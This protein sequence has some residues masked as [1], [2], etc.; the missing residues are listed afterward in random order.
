MIHRAHGAQ[1]QRTQSKTACLAPCPLWLTSV[2]SVTKDFAESV[3]Y[4][5]SPRML[6]D[7]PCSSV[8]IRG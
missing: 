4:R 1:I 5:A 6:S 3:N 7:Y 8:L 2:H